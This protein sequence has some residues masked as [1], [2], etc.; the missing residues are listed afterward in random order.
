MNRENLRDFAIQAQA[1]ID[2]GAV[3]DRIRHYL[4]SRL[5]S[6]FP[7]YPWWLQAHMQGTEEHVHFSSTHGNRDG[8]VDA[9]VGKT[10]IEYEKNLTIQGIFSEGYHQVKEYSAALCNIGIPESEVLS[11]L[12]DTV[13]WYGNKVRIVSEPAEGRLL[14]PDDVE[15]EQIMF[16]DLSVGTDEEFSRFEQFI[17]QFMARDESRILNAKTLVTDFGV[18]SSFYKTVLIS[19]YLFYKT[20]FDDGAKN[21]SCLIRFLRDAV[22]PCKSSPKGQK[23]TPS[24]SRKAFLLQGA[25]A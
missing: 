22:F 2:E 10:A 11:V 21:D 1:L 3:E 13:R 5:L 12:S 14:G 15:L 8:F 18:E 7:D 20:R 6:I 23:K 16:V 4:S 19:L 25:A 17:N 9:V 24:T